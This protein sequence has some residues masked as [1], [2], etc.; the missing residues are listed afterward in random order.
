MSHVK[1]VIQISKKMNPVLSSFILDRR[2]KSLKKNL[3][4]FERVTQ[5]KSQKGTEKKLK[6]SQKM[7][8]MYFLND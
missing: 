5:K 8:K 6:N 1:Y 4:A 2:R 7:K 3:C